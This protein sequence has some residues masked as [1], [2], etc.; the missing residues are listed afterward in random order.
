MFHSKFLRKMKV[1]EKS[2]LEPSTTINVYLVRMT[3]E[4]DDLAILDLYFSDD[5]FSSRK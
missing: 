1:V 4:L 2:E 3:P 5:P